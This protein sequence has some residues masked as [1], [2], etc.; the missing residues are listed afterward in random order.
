MTTPI[1]NFNVHSLRELSDLTRNGVQGLGETQQGESSFKDLLVESIEHVNTM[2][3]DADAA[4][5]TL[6]TGGDINPAEVLTA[7]QKA[8]MS[9]RMMQ[10]VRNKLVQAYQEIKD[11]RI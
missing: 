6:M 7:V 11:I 9:F 5:E 1:G 8:D 4:V 10:Q 2:Q 3:Q